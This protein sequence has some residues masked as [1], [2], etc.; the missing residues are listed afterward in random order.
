MNAVP[1]EGVPCPL[2]IL[3]PWLSG[4]R[5]GAT[6][7]KPRQH[8]RLDETS[9]SHAQVPPAYPR[10]NFPFSLWMDYGLSEC[11]AQK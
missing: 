3:S 8:R 1:K 6:K 5:C 4:N 7:P 11:E 9:W 10:S 2:A